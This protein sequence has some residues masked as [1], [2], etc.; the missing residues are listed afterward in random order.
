MTI[1][2]DTTNNGVSTMEVQRTPAYTI[3]RIKRKRDEEV[4]DVLVAEPSTKK[5]SK[6]RKSALDVFQYAETVDASMW[7]DVERQQ[8]LKDRISA[9]SNGSAPP[10]SSSPQKSS[11][12]PEATPMTRNV[13]STTNGPA[14]QYRVVVQDEKP[15]GKRD[16]FAQTPPKVLSSKDLSL[17]S[18]SGFRVYD[19]VLESDEPKGGETGIDDPEMEKFQSLLKDY[20]TVSE[21]NNS[22]P[23]SRPLSTP[24]SSLASIPMSA[25][26]TSI[27]DEYVYDVFYHRPTTLSQWTESG[28]MGT[29]VGLPSMLFDDDYEIDSESEEE[30][31]ADEDSNA[32]DFYANDYPDEEQSSEEEHYGSDGSDSEEEDFFTDERFVADE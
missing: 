23:P 10:A 7:K 29:L 32:E 25:S 12:P 26:S 6:R 20:L 16:R 4:P 14:R 21:S 24:S 2:V 30:D 5:G 3:L 13:S 18:S 8:E 27:S 28:N 19:A 11:I 31:E 1:P 15:K 22:L 17:S 9:L